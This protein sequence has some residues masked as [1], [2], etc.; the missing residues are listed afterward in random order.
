M[1]LLVGDTCFVFVL[2]QEALISNPASA[3]E[4]VLARSGKDPSPASLKGNRQ[5]ESTTAEPS[6][7]HLTGSQ[8]RWLQWDLL[9]GKGA[10]D[11]TAG[12][13]NE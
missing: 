7:A 4:K 12:K 11:S 3:D 2:M 1:Q 5:T 8:L 13:R 10:K 9:L 6:D